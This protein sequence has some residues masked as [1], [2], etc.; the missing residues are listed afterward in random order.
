[1]D[2]RREIDA[3]YSPACL[4]V[5]L[6]EDDLA[7]WALHAWLR[8]QLPRRLPDVTVAP[9]ARELRTQLPPPPPD[10]QAVGR[11]LLAHADTLAAELSG[12]DAQFTENPVANQL[13]HHDAFAVSPFGAYLGRG[14]A[15]PQFSP[16]VGGLLPFADGG[17][18]CERR[19]GDVVPAQVDGFLRPESRIVDD[20]EECDQ[21]RAAG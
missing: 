13:I 12:G 10:A 9:A 16:V 3:R 11:A 19:E 6:R 7:G 18:P 15:E 14:R 8:S 20:R 17:V 4:A 5:K 21:P 2:H 1:M